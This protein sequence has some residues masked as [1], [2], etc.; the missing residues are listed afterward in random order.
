MRQPGCHVRRPSVH[1]SPAGCFARAAV[2]AA[3]PRPLHLRRPLLLWRHPGHARRPNARRPLHCAR[4]L[5]AGQG[6][7]QALGAVQGGQQPVRRRAAGAAGHRPGQGLSCLGCCGWAAECCCG[8]SC[9][10]LAGP[11]GLLRVAPGRACRG[12]GAAA[13][14]LGALGGREARGRGWGAEGGRAPLQATAWCWLA[15]SQSCWAGRRARLA[16]MLGRS[17]CCCWA[18]ARLGHARVKGR[19]DGL[20]QQAAQGGGVGKGG[21]C[22]AA[23]CRLAGGTCV[24]Q[25]LTVDC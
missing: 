24:H 20:Q 15:C 16:G 14:W 18:A 3:Q 11:N 22:R 12:A 19:C 10:R 8:S 17:C 5:G 6:R 23:A 13:G 7:H 1:G 21:A 9:G 4:A 25:S 2:A